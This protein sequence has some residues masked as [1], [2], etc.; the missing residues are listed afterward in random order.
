MIATIL[1]ARPVVEHIKEKLIVRSANLKKQGITPTMSVV[2][3]GHNPASL[4]YIKNKKKMCEEIGA[5]FQLHQ[6]PTTVSKNDFL[7]EVETLNIDKSVHGIII[8]LPVSDHLK[9]LDIPNLIYPEKDIDGFHRFNTQKIYSGST[10]LNEL[11]PCTPK[12]I[13]NLLNYYHVPYAG[14][15]VVII[16]RSLIVGK[17]L[18]MLMSNLN[19]TVTLAH[20]HTLNLKEITQ[21]ADI[22][23]CAIGKTHFIDH[24][25]INEK[26]RT[27][28]I[29]VGMN[30]FNG[31]LTG[32]VNQTDVSALVPAMSPVPGGVGPMTVVSLLENLITATENQLK[33]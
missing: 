9:A 7:N 4:S 17:P 18:S 24:T 20:S 2:L 6:L 29:D 25:Y 28:I 33:G 13:V 12:G 3:V 11:L 26:K 19:A 23:I 32:D 1:L 22:L 14:K 27:V 10:N 16:G 8:Q 21:T 31:V 5:H 15:H 30:T